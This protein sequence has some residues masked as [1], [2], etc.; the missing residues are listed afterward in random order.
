MAINLVLKGIAF[1]LTGVATAEFY[2]HSTPRSFIPSW[3]LWFVSFCF[4]LASSVLVSVFIVF[5]HSLRETLITRVVQYW[6][7]PM[8]YPFAHA[9]L[10][11]MHKR[12]ARGPYR[13]I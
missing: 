13:E 4:T 1:I 5:E 7:I 10:M 12:A 8:L 6:V 3:I 2:I 9:L 11:E